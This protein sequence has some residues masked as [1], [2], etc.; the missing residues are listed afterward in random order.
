MEIDEEY[1]EILDDV[2]EECS[3]YG[4]VL[5][6]KIPRPKGV[7]NVAGLGKIFVE[8]GNVEQAKEA[9]RVKNDF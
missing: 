9:R 7:E 8:F 3:K 2:R 1:T 6:I 4:E 5:T